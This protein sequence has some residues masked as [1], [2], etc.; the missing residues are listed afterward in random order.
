MSGSASSIYMC[1]GTI[2]GEAEVPGKVRKQPAGGGWMK[3]TNC[4]LAAS[5]TMGQRFSLSVEGGADVTPIQITKTTDASSTGMFREA[6]LG[7][8]DQPAVIIFVRTGPAGPSEYMRFEL[9]NC[10]LVDFSI[11]SGGEERAIESFAI[12]YGRMT[13]ISMVYDSPGTP[14]AAGMAVVQNFA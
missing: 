1:Y 6:L 7:K 8:A 3:L 14:T 12:S 11:A 2:R 5:M 13:V 9:E 4:T 10:G